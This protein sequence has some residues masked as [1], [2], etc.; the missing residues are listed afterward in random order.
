[1]TDDS[2]RTAALTIEHDGYFRLQYRIA[3]GQMI[4]SLGHYYE[5][6]VREDLEMTKQLEPC[7]VVLAAIDH[8]PRRQRTKL[9]WYK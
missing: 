8:R 9:E 3:S 4:A 6:V 2:M 1:M 5:S 7:M